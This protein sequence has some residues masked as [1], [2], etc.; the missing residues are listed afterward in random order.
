[1]FLTMITRASLPT[2]VLLSG[3][4]VDKFLLAVDEARVEYDKEYRPEYERLRRERDEE[5]KVRGSIV[6]VFCTHFNRT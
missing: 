4:G 6:H 5:M 2:L 1:M 3:A